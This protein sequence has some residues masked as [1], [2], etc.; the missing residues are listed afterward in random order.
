MG[1]RKIARIA[2]GVLHDIG[3]AVTTLSLNMQLLSTAKAG[4]HLDTKALELSIL[5]ASEL[6]S[7]LYYYNSEVNSI[8]PKCWFDPVALVREALKAK[9]TQAEQLGIRMTSA[10]EPAELFGN[11]CDFSR[12]TLNLL[13]NAM[14]A[15]VSGGNKAREIFVAVYAETRGVVL[16]VRDNGIGMRH[17]QLQKMFSRHYSTKVAGVQPRVRGIGLGVVREAAERMGGTIIVSSNYGRG[18]EF[19]ILFSCSR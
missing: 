1:Y 18:S 19:R 5:S 3:N 11:K 4:E 7:L 2:P 8:Q 10:L 12:I 17:R 14:E 6:E 13:T 15:V 9:Q 16:V